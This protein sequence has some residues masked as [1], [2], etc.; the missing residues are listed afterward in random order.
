MLGGINGNMAWHR[1]E[2]AAWQ[3]RG[4][5]IRRRKLAAAAASAAS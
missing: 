2:T 4:G 3:N 5:V 1:G